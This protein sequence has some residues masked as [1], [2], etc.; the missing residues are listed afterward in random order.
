MPHIPTARP[1]G[2]CSHNRIAGAAFTASLWHAAQ[3]AAAQILQ[4]AAKK[5]KP[6]AALPNFDSELNFV[7]IYAGAPEQML[8]W[9]EKAVK[10]GEPYAANEFWWPIPS[11]ARKTERF[12]KLMREIGL[13]ETWRANG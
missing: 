1:A 6:P 11:S 8:D 10:S 9:P 2:H 5:E 7:Y 3:S 4:S 12:E 13:A